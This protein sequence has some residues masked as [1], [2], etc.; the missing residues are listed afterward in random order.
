[1]LFVG[2]DVIGGY[3]T[4]INVTSP[5]GVR[6]L[7]KQFNTDIAGLLMDA[8]EKRL[9]L[10]ADRMTPLPLPEH[11]S[12]AI[13]ARRLARRR[14]AG[15]RSADDDAVP[16]RAVPRHRDSRRHVRGCR[17]GDKRPD[18]DARSAA[19]DGRRHARGGQPERAIPRATQSAR[20]RH[21]RRARAARE[22]GVVGAPGR[23]RPA[24]RTATAASI[25]R[26]SRGQQSD[27]DS[28]AAAAIAAKSNIAAAK[29]SPA[30]QARGAAGA[31]ADHAAPDRDQRDRQDAALARQARGRH[32]RDR[33][34]HARV[35]AGA[36]PRRLAPQ[37][38]AAR[39][40]ELSADRAR[41]RRRQSGARSLDPRAT[42]ASARRRHAAPAAARRSIRRRCRSCG[43]PRRSIR[44]RRSCA[45]STTSCASPTNGSSWTATVGRAPLSDRACGNRRDPS[46][47]YDAC[48]ALT[49]S[50]RL[51][52]RVLARILRR[53]SGRLPHEP[54]PD[55]DAGDDG[56]QF[57]ADRHV[58]LGTQR[59]RR[60]RHHHQPPAADA[61]RRRLR[62]TE[63]A[64]GAG[65][66]RQP[67][68]A[69]R[70]PGADRSRLRRA[71]R[72]RPVGAHA[73]GVLAHP[74]HDFARHSRR[75]G[76]RQRPGDGA[77]GARLCGLERRSAR[78]RDSRRTPGSRCRATSASCST[79]PTSNAGA[80]PGACSA[81]TWRPSV[82]RSG[83]PDGGR[84]RRN[85]SRRN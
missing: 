3:V 45:S 32:V 4:E 12:P 11:R 16:G 53:M 1:M 18:A 59:G 63:D 42:A 73:P 64:D 71:P 61:A 56:Q 35:E 54:V 6:E 20:Q 67:A 57:L 34:Q 13:A 36:L 68:G 26:R 31:L 48:L 50:S 62:A 30:Q 21:D 75:H 33:S 78:K 66:E 44:F 72:R 8:I 82:R 83:M 28:S 5:T 9:R 46:H 19:A 65:R 22:S 41:Q 38:R 7:D 15:Q 40:A 25:A 39:H 2:L 24:C 60:A 51:S 81:S 47:D 74:G 52:R 80:R 55:R 27:R 69:A 49:G 58:H 76:A 29:I 77:G 14:R 17:R 79:R 37:G 23:S 10:R 85:G 43:W 70:R 84:R